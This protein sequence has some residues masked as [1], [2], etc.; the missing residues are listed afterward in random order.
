MRKTELAEIGVQMG[1]E[2]YRLCMEKGMPTEELLN[3][4]EVC[5][6]A[7]K[8]RA[9]LYKHNEEIP[10]YRGLYPRTAVMAYLMK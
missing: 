9:W 2:Y 6:L 8:S 10:H 3:A 5:E 4:E 7:K 1:R